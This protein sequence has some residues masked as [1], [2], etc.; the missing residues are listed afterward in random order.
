[1]VP[2]TL[3]TKRKNTYDITLQAAWGVKCEELGEITL[4]AFRS[5]KT[6]S[7]RPKH[8]TLQTVRSA[9]VCRVT[10]KYVTLQ[11]CRRSFVFCWAAPKRMTLQPFGSVKF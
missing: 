2:P 6:R 9:E 7:A 4:K 5:V 11:S 8:I 3:E 10:S 1:M